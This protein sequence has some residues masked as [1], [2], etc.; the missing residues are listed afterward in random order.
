MSEQER[1]VVDGCEYECE[2]LASGLVGAATFPSLLALSQSQVFKRLR[3]SLSPGL[4]SSLLGLAS[5]SFAGFGA[6]LAALKTLT[7]VNQYFSPSDVRLSLS[8]RDV[9]ISTVSSVVVFRALGG[10]FNAVLPS[11]LMRPG[12][13]AMEWIPAMK[14]SQAAT[15]K[16]REVI[17]TLGQNHG[18]HSC[19][20]RRGVEF[21]ADHQPPSRLLGNHRNGKTGPINAISANPLVQRFYPQC[22][23]CSR[24]QG[25]ILGGFNGQALSH[26]QAIRT[27]VTSFRPHHVF[28]PIPFIVAYLNETNRQK[29]VRTIPR[30]LVKAPSPQSTAERTGIT[31]ARA[32]AT[33][34]ATPE[35]EG[36]TSPQAG[37]QKAKPTEV[38]KE[39]AGSERSVWMDVEVALKFPLFIVW[40]KIVQFLDSFANPLASFHVTLWAFTIIAA[41]GTA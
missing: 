21:V 12:A 18:C 35:T 32:T 40:H 36:T 1:G 27:H 6:S 41:L 3:V 29:P 25:G 17:K 26:T 10:R 38:A 23:R 16:E 37:K 31:A 13:F 7:I 19:G 15:P 22:V 2:L 30:D 11:N 4:V 34:S 5:V 24:I 33:D 8:R 14:E 39:A 9:L 28:L 20:E